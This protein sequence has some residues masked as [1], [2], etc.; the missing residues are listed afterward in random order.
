MS[1]VGQAKRQAEGPCWA[2]GAAIRVTGL[3][4]EPQT[5]AQMSKGTLQDV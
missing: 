2:G 3:Q 5:E 1:E 4:K